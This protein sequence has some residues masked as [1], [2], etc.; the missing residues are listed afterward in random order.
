MKFFKLIDQIYRGFLK[1]LMALLAI[2]MFALV[3]TT[4][5]QV[6]SRYFSHSPQVWPTDIA[7][8]ALVFL[9]YI[10]MG[11]LLREDGHTRVDIVYNMLPHSGKYILNIVM[12]IIGI[13]TL[14]TVTYFAVKLDISYFQKDTLLIGSA[15]Y[16][17]KFII[18]SFIPIG[19]AVTAIE[20]IRRLV[21][22]IIELIKK[23]EAEEEG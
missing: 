11:I 21:M 9:T 10:G 8:Y 17:P 22:D 18:F 3:I 2:V 7:T 16:T 20:Y 5:W 4:T 15:F 6:L 12:D 14:C 13:A 1:V 23:P 19:L